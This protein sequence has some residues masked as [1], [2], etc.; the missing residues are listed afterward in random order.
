MGTVAN[1]PRLS[2]T[3]GFPWW[4]WAFGAKAKRDP[5]Q[6]GQLVTVAWESIVSG[7]LG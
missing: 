3:E 7:A 5:G 6:S 1:H 4:L 2:E